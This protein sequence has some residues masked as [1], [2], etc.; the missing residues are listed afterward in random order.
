MRIYLVVHGFVQ[1]IGYRYLVRRTAMRH[2]IRGF[3]RNMPD[4]SVAILAEGGEE[5]IEEFEKEINVDIEHGPQVHN[6]E[7]FAEGSA[8]FPRNDKRY[9]DFRAEKD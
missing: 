8:G 9:E 1:G 6:V 3:V 5:E 7:R 2:N 4:G